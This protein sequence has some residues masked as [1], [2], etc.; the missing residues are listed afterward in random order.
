MNIRLATLLVATLILAG[1]KQRTFSPTM[2]SSENPGQPGQSDEAQ[3]VLAKW[4]PYMVVHVTGEAF[5]AYRDLLPQMV[6][7]GTLRGVRIGTGKN[8]AFDNYVVDMIRGIP[9]IDILFIVDNYYLFDN[10]IERVI[11]DALMKYPDIRYFQIGNETTTIVAGG[12]GPDI[13]IEEYMAQ[14][15]RAYDHV[16]AK[17]PGRAI[18]VTQSTLGAGSYGAIELEKMYQL[19]LNRMSP[20]KVIIGINCYSPAAATQ[21]AGVVS[22]SLRSFRIWVTETG[23]TDPN[24]HAGYVRT[25]YP[26]I[27][28]TLR[29]E[30]IYW[31]AAWAGDS[32]EGHPNSGD[33]GFG[34][35]RQPGKFPDYLK[36]PLLKMLL[37]QW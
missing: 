34:L 31:Y 9:G 24:L 5:D 16:Q 21:Y 35:I 12:G 18:L 30:R 19:G 22:G 32:W 17:H 4:S 36:M 23:D 10:N 7:K 6:A 20:E 13:T 26:E 1:C 27:R 29:A 33:E 14:F 25:A 11:D 8:E 15:N 37:G 2:P 28:N 3:D